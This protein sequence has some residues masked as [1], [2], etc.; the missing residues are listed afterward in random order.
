MS[1]MTSTIATVSPAATRPPT[2]TNGGAPGD[3]AR[4][5]RPTEGDSTTVP[6]PGAASP[7]AEGGAGAGAPSDGDG[8]AAGA[9]AA[10]SGGDGT[11]A[12]AGS[13]ASGVKGGAEAA[14]PSPPA[15]R[16]TWSVSGPT[17]IVISCQSLRSKASKSAFMARSFNSMLS[18]PFVSGRV[19]VAPGGSA[20]RPPHRPGCSYPNAA[21]ADATP[22]R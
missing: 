17:E 1:F 4:Q 16:E 11:A 10:A 9:D 5:K 12:G 6:V 3:G 7:A 22:D 20:R 2:S 21:R 8:A 14:A 13:A 18:L 19:S 15:W